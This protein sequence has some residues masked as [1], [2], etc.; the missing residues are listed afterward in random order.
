M[1][2][3]LIE[4]MNVL[5]HS[6]AVGPILSES[7]GVI[8][9]ACFPSDFRTGKQVIFTRMSV[10]WKSLGLKETPQ[11]LKAAEFPLLY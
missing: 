1:T 5:L 2:Y 6:M 4:L 3:F 9:R 7:G 10:L 8:C 11:L